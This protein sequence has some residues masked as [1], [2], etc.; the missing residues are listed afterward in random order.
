[1]HNINLK[2]FLIF[3]VVICSWLFSV[4]FIPIAHSASD[5]PFNET[6]C[7]GQCGR[8]VDSDK[9]SFC[10]NG[11]L[12]AST[13]AAEN[14]S[15][16]LEKNNS[17]EQITIAKKYKVW[18]LSMVVIILYAISFILQR[19]KKITLLTHKKIWN[20][21]LLFSFL[22]SGILGMFLA[23]EIYFSLPF[24]FSMMKLHVLSGVMMFWVTLFH[25]IERWRFFRN[26]FGKK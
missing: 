7:T 22:L 1:M 9:D 11:K 14:K 23:L 25:I 6:D 4:S 24:S 15:I 5:C 12:S 21:V 18:E 8:F 17:L 10:D 13:H 3:S 26:M 20:T 19:L 2:Q 16:N